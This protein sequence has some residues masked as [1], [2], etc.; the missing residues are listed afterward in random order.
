M[1][2]F[3]NSVKADL[4]DR[5]IAPLVAVGVVALL[6]AVGYVAFGGGSSSSTPATGSTPALSAAAGGIAVSQPTTSKAVA[7]TTSGVAEQR[8]GA[9][10]NPFAPL[11]SVARLQAA[12]TAK[13]AS[14]T[15]VATSPPS[16]SSSSASSSSS[17]GSGS[18]TQPKSEPAPSTPVKPSPPAKP[19]PVYDVA[20]LFGVIPPETPAESAQ[21]TP[22]ENIKLF[23]ALPSAQLPLIAYRGVTAKGKS[24][25][26]TLV[27]E[28]I[29]H[30]G[31]VCLPSASQCQA[32]GLKA[33][34]TEQLEYLTPGGQ[35]IT[36]ELRIVSISS[37][38]ASAAS[39]KGLLGASS[40]AGR[41]LLRREGLM[42]LP[43]L[44]YSPQA[45]V[46]VLAGH[47]AFTAHSSSRR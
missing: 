13:T 15:S 18:F 23:T 39:V 16:S 32:I 3:L 33:G 35:A 41:E 36:Y 1:S 26:F 46:L 11:P 9:A 10:R 29:L 43:G 22:Y 27:G 21:L 14:A 40:M 5:R 34:Q 38:S 37:K 6:A 42:T 47:P 28:V 44:R 19:Q 7:E 30:G 4:L 8:Q 20:V 2:A 45:G 24:A 12:E 31:A 25:T 17:T